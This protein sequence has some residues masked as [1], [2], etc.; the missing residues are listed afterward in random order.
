MFVYVDAE[1]ARR[2]ADLVDRQRSAGTLLSSVAGLPVSIKD[3]FDVEGQTTTAGSRSLRSEPL[4]SRDATAVARLRRAGAVIIGRTN[5]TEFA[6]TGVG[7][8]PHW[9]TPANRYE[10]D[11]R[12]I[13]GGS[14][15]GAAVSVTDGMAFAAVGSDTGGSVRIPAALCGITGFKATQHRIPRDGVF[16]L[17]PTL[18][19]VGILAVSVEDC[20][21]FDAVL[22]GEDPQ[23]LVPANLRSIVGVIP[24]SYFVEGLEAPVAAAFDRAVTAL[25][26]AGMRLGDMGFPEIEEIASVNARGGLAAAEAYR[27]HS[28]LGTDFASFDPLVRERIVRGGQITGSEYAR[29]LERRAAIVEQFDRAHDSVDVMICPVVPMIAPEIRAL[30]ADPD[31]FRRVNARLLRNPSVVNFLDRCALSLPCHSGGGPPVGL[32]LIGRRS[33]D[34]ALL[35]V[36]AAVEKVIGLALNR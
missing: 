6:F 25:S 5:M 35:S 15:S 33:G 32:M 14:S 34:R 13:P 10:R 9:G 22:A 8:N 29:M 12:R 24:R 18:D 31:E 36:G 23:E 30:E 28:K 26:S 1:G 19:S 3:L 21:A 2:A 20:A 17:S 4:A 7:I 27:F 16:P 11:K